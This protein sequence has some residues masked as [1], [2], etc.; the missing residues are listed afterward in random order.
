MILIQF[1]H[2]Q[3][4]RE[5]HAAPFANFSPP[6]FAEGTSP[7][8]LL[9]RALVWCLRLFANWQERSN[10][11]GRHKQCNDLMKHPEATSKQDSQTF[12]RTSCM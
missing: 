6:A 2:D 8:P 5:F 11:L 4:C 1:C 3:W 7:P 10:I 9:R 12:T